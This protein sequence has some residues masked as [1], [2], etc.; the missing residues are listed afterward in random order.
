MCDSIKVR[1]NIAQRSISG[2]R[3]GKS[4]VILYKTDNNFQL[5]Y[6]QPGFTL[7]GGGVMKKQD[8]TRNQ[9]DIIPS[10]ATWID[11]KVQKFV[12]EKNTIILK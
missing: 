8:V 2:R 6:Y 10:G 7:V 12:P 9:S 1:E 3:A 5:H 11:N 4:N